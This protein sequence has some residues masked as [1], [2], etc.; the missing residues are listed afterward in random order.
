MIDKIDNSKEFRT[1]VGEKLLYII[2]RCEDH[3]KTQIVARLFA[4][5]IH[6]RI[7][8]Q[9][10]LQASSIVER[11]MLDDLRYFLKHDLDRSRV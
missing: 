2:D 4:A 5:F 11:I 8:Y 3:E 6:D 9:D 10:F 7:T 1:R